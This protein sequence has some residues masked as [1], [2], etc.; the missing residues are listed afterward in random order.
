MTINE[1]STTNVLPFFV[2]K[3]LPSV[4]DSKG[5]VIKTNQFGQK[6]RLPLW[7]ILNAIKYHKPK[8]INN[9]KQFCVCTAVRSSMKKHHLFNTIR[10]TT[11][12]LTGQ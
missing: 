2:K 3:T 8:T 11:N 5:I 10:K 1:G 12:T 7:A 4:T 9:L 6:H